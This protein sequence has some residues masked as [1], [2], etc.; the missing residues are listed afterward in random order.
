MSTLSVRLHYRP[1]R[2]GWCLA[3]DDMAKLREA[4]R[5]SFS[6][7]GGRYNPIIPLGNPDLADSLIKLFRVDVLVPVSDLP[8]VKAFVEGRRHLSSPLSHRSL[9]A[10]LGNGRKSATIADL[11]HPITKIYE[12]RHKHN[13]MAEP[14]VDL[15]KWDNADPLADMFLILFGALPPAAECGTDYAE[16]IRVHL[17]GAT[18]EISNGGDVPL[19]TKNRLTLSKLGCAFVE[20]H[21]VV[22]NYRNHA[23]FYVGDCDRFDDLVNFWNLRVRPT[24]S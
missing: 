2:I 8:E 3:A 23:G 24:H 6:M 1:L 12:D 17:G 4:A 5:W 20:Q 14:S 9:F 16:L 19:L 13:T 10:D 11:I 18:K 15:H 7:W 21:Y 22:R